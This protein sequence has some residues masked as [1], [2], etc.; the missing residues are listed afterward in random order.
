MVVMDKLVFHK[1]PRV[2][3]TRINS[4][5]ITE[6]INLDE[7]TVY[8]VYKRRWIGVGIIMLLNI[9]SSWRYLTPLVRGSGV[10]GLHLLL[11]RGLL[12]ITLD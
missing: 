2:Q 5:E 1:R 6:E 10:V 4:A 7:T 12:G 8:R 9:V 3:A 11:S